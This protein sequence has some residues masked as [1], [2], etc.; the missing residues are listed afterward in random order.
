MPPRRQA[1]ARRLPLADANGGYDEATAL[2][3][4]PRL[5]DLGVPCRATPARQPAHRLPQAQER[6]GALP[7]IMDEGVVSSVE[8]AE[9]HQ[10]GLLDGVAMKPARCGGLADACAGRSSTSATTA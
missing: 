8:L 10:L 4:A 3:V 6:Q 9:F 7:I 5:A 1:G 2:A